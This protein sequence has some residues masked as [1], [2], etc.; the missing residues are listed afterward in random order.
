MV[1][2]SQVKNLKTGDITELE[3]NG[4]FFAIGH[5]AASAVRGFPI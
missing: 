5:D 4:L 1:V 3:C 2:T